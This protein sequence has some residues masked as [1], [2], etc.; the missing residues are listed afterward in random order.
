[1][2]IVGRNVPWAFFWPWDVLCRG[3]FRDGTFESRTFCA[4]ERLVPWDV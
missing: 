1:V 4:V 3:T 2:T